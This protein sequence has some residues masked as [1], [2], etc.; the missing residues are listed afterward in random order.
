MESD[1][2]TIL[3]AVVVGAAIVVLIG[4]PFLI[5]LYYKIRHRRGHRSRRS[6]HRSH[7]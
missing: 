6:A 1:G 5:G 3:L 2:K 4:P 7:D